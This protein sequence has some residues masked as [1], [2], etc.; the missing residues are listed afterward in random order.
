MVSANPN[1]ANEQNPGIAGVTLFG[2]NFTAN[3]V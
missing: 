1:L 2:I 3:N